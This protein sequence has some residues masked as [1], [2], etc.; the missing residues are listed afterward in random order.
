MQKFVQLTM[1]FYFPMKVYYRVFN[2][3]EEIPDEHLDEILIVDQSRD[4]RRCYHHEAK[5]E[6]AGDLGSS[7]SPIT[8]SIFLILLH[9]SIIYNI[10]VVKC[11][12]KD[13]DKRDDVDIRKS[14]SDET[15]CLRTAAAALGFAMSNTQLLYLTRLSASIVRDL[16]QSY[17]GRSGSVTQ[18][19]SLAERNN[20]NLFVAASA[21]CSDAA[22]LNSRN[23]TLSSSVSDKERVRVKA[24]PCSAEGISV[25]EF[26]SG[27]G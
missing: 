15:A 8:R 21:S 19:L 5:V 4:G 13:N 20:F 27:I 23:Q 24:I 3:S 26:F 2:P 10:N 18:N 6:V 25:L 1:M 7:L 14:V 11:Q 22:S 16:T 17:K 12:R 9:S